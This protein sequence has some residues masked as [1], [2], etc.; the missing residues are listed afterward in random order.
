MS[1]GDEKEDY[2]VDICSDNIF[3]D[4]S[5]D[6]VAVERQDSTTDGN[7][8]RFQDIIKI[9]GN[10]GQAVANVSNHAK[11]KHFVAELIRLLEIVKGNSE[12]VQEMSEAN[13]L[14]GHFSMYHSSST[15]ANRVS[16]GGIVAEGCILEGGDCTDGEA[17]TYQ[18]TM[19]RAAPAPPNN[20]GKK[21]LRSGMEMRNA[22]HQKQ[23]CSL[24]GM[25]GHKA[26]GTQCPVV[27]RCKAPLIPWRDI[28]NMAGRLGNPEYFE[29]KQ[30]SNVTRLA[31][32]QHL[33][34]GSSIAI[35][36]EACHLVLLN[37]YCLQ[38][39]NKRSNFNWIEVAVLGQR[40]KELPGWERAY[41]PDYQIGNWLRKHCASPGRKK[42]VLSALR[43][44][45]ADHCQT[46]NT[47]DN[48]CCI[49]T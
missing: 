48:S 7:N 38:T 16:K 32:Q 5:V 10:L 17:V 4:E 34:Q 28:E 15:G 36:L 47:P 14:G 40:G 29:V 37:T 42:N 33:S 9:T 12:T 19:K 35:P 13:L 1:V 44:R 43:C 8:L 30:T 21:R 41:F 39:E 45:S 46:S 24:C 3:D 22:N 11:K 23:S 26:V 27:A 2:Q 49:S 20:H 31:I 25:V 6:S 18:A